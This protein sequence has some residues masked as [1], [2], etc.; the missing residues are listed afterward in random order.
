AEADLEKAQVMVK[1]A[2][3]V[4]PYDGVITER[5]FF[6]GDFVKSAAQGGS[7]RPLFTVECTDKMRIV[8][9][10]PDR[11][12]PFT[13]PGDEAVVKLDALPGEVFK[14]HVSRMAHSEDP[15]TRLMRVEIDLDNPKG[16][17]RQGMYGQVT[18]ILDK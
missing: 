13:D 15:Q 18:I 4:S 1:F 17:I 12:V 14:A 2:T 11:D 16:K 9:Q 8:T 3:I 5:N 6:R 10:V 7:Q